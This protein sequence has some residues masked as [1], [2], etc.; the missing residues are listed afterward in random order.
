MRSLK[1]LAITTTYEIRNKGIEN[2]PLVIEHPRQGELKSAQPFETTDGFHRFHVTLNPGQSTP[3]ES[4]KCSRTTQFRLDE[5]TREELVMFS[6]QEVPQTIRQKLGE[7][8]DFQSKSKRCKGAR[9]YREG[10]Q[11]SLRGSGAASREPQGIARQHR[12]P[13][14]AGPIPRSTQEAGRPD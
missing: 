1:E 14:T 7:I 13:A 2:K 11:D 8:V 6:S 4:R 9:N 10:N 5:L 12:R 3:F